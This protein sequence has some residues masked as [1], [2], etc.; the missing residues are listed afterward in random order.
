MAT[1]KT[2]TTAAKKAPTKATAAKKPTAKK[3][4]KTADGMFAVIY[5]GGKQHNV[6][7]GDTLKIEK[8]E[9]DFKMGDTITF[10]KVMLIDDGATTTV[11]APYLAT[12]TVTSEFVRAARNKTIN[13]IKYKQKSRYFK[14]KGHRQHFM[15]VKITNIA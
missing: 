1:A 14:K 15:E 3:A 9:G 13:V 5:A 7:V 8:M 2:T 10:D 4:R 6:M 11:G 12:N